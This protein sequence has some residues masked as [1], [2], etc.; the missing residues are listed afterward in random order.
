LQVHRR[1][2]DGIWTTAEDIASGE[3][4]RG[5]VMVAEAEDLLYALYTSWDSSRDRIEYRT[6][7]TLAGEPRETYGTACRQPD[8]SWQIVN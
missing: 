3:A 2:L 8:G 5:I 7:A 1:D 6:A 4:T